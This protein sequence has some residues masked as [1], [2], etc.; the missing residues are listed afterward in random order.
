MANESPVDFSATI[1]SL[2]DALSNIG[3]VQVELLDNGI[4]SATSTLESWSP[5]VVSAVENLTGTLNQVLQ[6]ISA[7]MAPKQ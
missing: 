4:K 5:V 2:T 7:S 6:G 1:G 3:Q